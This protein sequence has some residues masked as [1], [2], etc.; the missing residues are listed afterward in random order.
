MLIDSHAH[1]VSLENLPDVLQ[2]AKESEICKIL[3]ISSDLPSSLDTIKLAKET[4]NVYASV[5]I[6]PHEVTGYTPEI[7]SRLEELTK[8]PKVVAIGET[9]LDYF[10]MNSE[11][12]VQKTSFIEQIKLANRCSLPLII[13][14]RDAD[15]DLISILKSEDISPSTGVIHCFTGN[16]ETAVQYLDM[17]F[18]ISFSGIV[19]FKRS[20]ELREAAKKIPADKILIETDSPYLAPMPY[21]GKPNEPSYVKFVAETLADVRGTTIEQ[22][23]ALTAVNAETLFQLNHQS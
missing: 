1:L 8:E 7:I 14:V 6:H 21:R 3:S 13:H 23:A 4:G 11:K 19:T 16:Y 5:G 12:E 17:G 15:E 2:R 9:G 20:E 18:Y 22:I 10:Y